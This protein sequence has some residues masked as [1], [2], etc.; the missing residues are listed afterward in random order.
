MRKKIRLPKMRFRAS[1]AH[2]G[3]TEASFPAGSRIE[4][5]GFD[6]IRVRDRSDDE[7][8]DAVAVMYDKGR[9]PEIDEDDFHFA[10]VIAVDRTGSI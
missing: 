3:R 5:I 7:L 4:K 2:S 6:E 8:R 1:Y 10:S 9:V